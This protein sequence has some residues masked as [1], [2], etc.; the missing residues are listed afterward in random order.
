MLFDL[1][2]RGLA[3]DVPAGF[4]DVA[5]AGVLRMMRGRAATELPAGMWL[6]GSHWGPGSGLGERTWDWLFEDAMGAED[7]GD[8]LVQRHSALGGRA[9]ENERL[10][11]PGASCPVQFDASPTFHTHYLVHEATR[12]QIARLLAQAL[13]A[14]PGASVQDA[15][16][17]HA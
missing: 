13:A 15:K 2:E 1:L 8:G 6:V 11:A 14:G 17:S 12:A 4:R 16:G 9:A 5:P 7:E 10:R 3:Y